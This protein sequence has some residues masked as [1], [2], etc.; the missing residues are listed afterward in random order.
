MVFSK[1][2]GTKGVK[3]F[4]EDFDFEEIKSAFNKRIRDNVKQLNILDELVINW[5]QT[6]VNL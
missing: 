3:H 4:P 2:K 6:G 5:D 1:R